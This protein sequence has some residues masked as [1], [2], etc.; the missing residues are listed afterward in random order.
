MSRFL[1]EESSD[2]PYRQVAGELGMNE[3]VVKAAAHRM[4][5]RF[6]Q[7]LRDEVGRA[8]DDPGRINEEIRYQFPATEL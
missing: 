6:G 5:K 3:S 8:V 7:M 1:T 2:A 4:R